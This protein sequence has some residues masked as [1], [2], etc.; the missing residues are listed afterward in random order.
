MEDTKYIYDDLQKMQTPEINEGTFVFNNDTTDLEFI[1]FYSNKELKKLVFQTPQPKLRYLDAGDCSLEEIVFAKE[2]MSFDSLQ[3][4]YLHQNSLQKFE[5]ETQMPKLELL[6]LSKNKISELPAVIGDCDKL[7]NLILYE[8]DIS[9]P[10]PEIVSS[11]VESIKSHFR[12][13]KE[14]GAEYWYEAKMLILGHAKSGKTSLVRRIKDLDAPLPKDDERTRGIDIFPWSFPL[15]ESKGTTTDYKVYIWDFGGQQIYHATHRFFLTHRA[16]YVLVIDASESKFAD[17][18]YWFHHIEKFG[19]DSPALIVVNEKEGYTFEFDNYDKLRGRFQNIK[20]KINSDIKVNK[21]RDKYLEALKYLLNTLPDTGSPIPAN[22]KKVRDELEKLDDNYISSEKFYEIC[23]SYN[24]DRKTANEISD[25]LHKLGV[26]LHFTESDLLQRTIFLKPEW[27]TGA[28]YKI[29][30]DPEIIKNKGEFYRD[31]AN[32]IWK[33]EQYCDVVGAL[34]EMMNNFLLA[35]EIP[36]TKKYIVPQLLS[37]EVPKYNA[38]TDDF[39]TITYLFEEFMP[40][41]LIHQ[42][43]VSMHR[44]IPEHDW[45]WSK[46]VILKDKNSYAEVIEEYSESKIKIRVSGEYPKD[47]IMRIV[48]CLDGMNASYNNKLKFDKWIPC[49]CSTCS[50]IIPPGEPTIFS[51]EK[52]RKYAK[53][54]E[55]IKCDE[56]FEMI[57]AEALIDSVIDSQ[58]DE[59]LVFHHRQIPK[60]PEVEK[61]KIL[62]LSANPSNEAR[63]QT[64][65]EHKKIDECLL[66]AKKRDE[67]DIPSPQFSVTIDDLLR[68]MNTEPAIIHFAGHSEKE[69]IYIVND[70]NK[71]HLLKTEVLE[72]IFQD[73]K[74]TTQLV[75]LNACYSTEQAK[76]LSALGFYVVG[77]NKTINDNDAIT[78]A[79]GLYLGLGEGNEIT[80]AFKTGKAKLMAFSTKETSTPELWK[81]GKKLDI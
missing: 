7:R 34:L 53:N 78:F 45:V 80:K 67:F 18:N 64:G 21:N 56:S 23:E 24:L 9:V 73:Y 59:K 61:T 37:D 4:L 66:K 30:D 62:F 74:K 6:D 51:F 5:V 70:S 75:V 10:P 49:N 1:D 32:C 46:G 11:G 76:T 31:D 16:V 79:T 8:N 54:R 57:S 38:I 47:M 26:I 2:I 71:S 29:L 42:F 65:F 81:D 43:I 33:D 58:K 20:E 72:Y 13:L 14:E 50:N 17:F 77:M 12:R 22:T 39:K 36:D 27:V 55:K 15:S 63:L 44:F 68:L 35:Y 48:D 52:L 40:R 69:G 3:T 41:G 60:E 19:G 25:F 28:V